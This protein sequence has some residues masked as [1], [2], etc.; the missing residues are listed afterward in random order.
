MWPRLKQL[1]VSLATAPVVA[2][3]ARVIVLGKI[4]V[5]GYA[6]PC[7]AS[8]VVPMLCLGAAQ[9]S[10]QD[11]PRLVSKWTWH[12]KACV[13]DCFCSSQNATQGDLYCSSFSQH[14]KPHNQIIKQ[15]RPLL[16][17]LQ[18]EYPR[19]RPDS[20]SSLSASRERRF[21]LSLRS[22]SFSLLACKQAH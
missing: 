11:V 14:F 19:S 6:P 5:F 1:T 8:L 4:S 12:V 2:L 21:S 10:C 17:L 22:R 7:L 20:L 9:E 18:R 13:L 15:T 16:W 3:F